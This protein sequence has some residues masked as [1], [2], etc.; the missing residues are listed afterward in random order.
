MEEALVERL[1]RTLGALRRIAGGLEDL[2][3]S[4]VHR[5]ARRARAHVA[6]GAVERFLAEAVPL[7]ELVGHVAHDVGSRHVGAAR[8]LVVARPEI[9]HDRL[10]RLDL[11]RARVA[12]DRRLRAVRHAELV[13]ARTVRQERLRDGCSDPLGRERGTVDLEPFAVLPCA[14]QEVAR[15]RHARLAR[16]LRA[17]D[18]RELRVALHTPPLDEQV[19]VR[20]ELDAPGTQLVREQEGERPGHRRLLD[21]ERRHGAERHLVVD[22][23]PAQAAA[24][25]LVGAEL[26]VRMELEA[27]AREA[28]RL[29]GAHDDMAGAVAF[30]IQERI[31]DRHGHLVPELCRT[32]RVGVDEDVGHRRGTLAG[33]TSFQGWPTPSDARSSSSPGTTGRWR[34]CCRRRARSSTPTCTSGGT[35]TA[36]SGTTTSS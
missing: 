14:A 21:A 18:T 8:G 23:E 9:D 16:R 6:H 30:R 29:E 19:L 12:A 25:Q 35:S 28:R 2:A 5:L 20:H 26:L 31:A 13:P 17:P 3:A 34:S 22:L 4:V 33:T 32:E 10:A 7:G 1:A 24:P 27:E 11:P 15:G 36:W